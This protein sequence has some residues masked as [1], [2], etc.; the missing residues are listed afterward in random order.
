MQ[1]EYKDPSISSPAPE[2]P[3]P[4]RVSIVTTDDN[5]QKI[6]VSVSPQSYMFEKSYSTNIVPILGRNI[7]LDMRLSR[8]I[9]TS[10][11]IFLETF[12]D[13]NRTPVF[14]IVKDGVT[15]IDGLDVPWT[16]HGNRQNIDM[17]KK[18]HVKWAQAELDETKNKIETLLTTAISTIDNWVIVGRIKQESRDGLVAEA[19]KGY[20]KYTKLCDDLKDDLNSFFDDAP[21]LP[22][23]ESS[24]SSGQAPENIWLKQFRSWVPIASLRRNPSVDREG[25]FVRYYPNPRPTSELPAGVDS[26]IQL[27]QFLKNNLV[28]VDSLYDNTYPIKLAIPQVSDM[29]LYPW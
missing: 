9:V 1:P 7:D 13:R 4:F 2:T 8:S 14:S 24:T 15:Y 28:L 11:D 20:S 21:F 29:S 10:N 17:I 3:Y 16:R 5:A 27:V 23:P 25:K 6:T 26:P 19:R 22:A 12:Y 18:A